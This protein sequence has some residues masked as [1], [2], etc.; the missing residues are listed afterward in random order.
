MMMG[1]QRVGAELGAVGQ[2]QVIA[3]VQLKVSMIDKQLDVEDILCLYISIA[4]ESR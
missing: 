3:I 1:V 4:V 2:G